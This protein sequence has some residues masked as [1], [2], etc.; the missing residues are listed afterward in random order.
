MASQR[1]IEANCRNRALRGPLSPEARRKL[2]EAALKN[3]PWDRSTG[4]RTPEG[5]ARSSM[6]ALKHGKFGGDSRAWRR[7][8]FRFLSLNK[9]VRDAIGGRTVVADPLGVIGELA[10]LAHRLKVNAKRQ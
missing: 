4:P 5:K 10:R 1:Q 8:A 6:N 3:R 9:Q 2:S 7:D